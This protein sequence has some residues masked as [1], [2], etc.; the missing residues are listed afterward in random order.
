MASNFSSIFTP[1]ENAEFEREAEG[2]RE[3]EEQRSLWIEGK[4]NRY[5]ALAYPNQPH[6]GSRET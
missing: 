4:P 3:I 6:A 2:S 5:F 1:E